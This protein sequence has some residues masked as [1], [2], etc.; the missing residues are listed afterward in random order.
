MVGSS[1]HC[2]REHFSLKLLGLLPMKINLILTSTKATRKALFLSLAICFWLL[3]PKSM[4]ASEVFIGVQVDGEKENVSIEVSQILDF[5]S[6]S[7]IS[8]TL[9]PSKP[10]QISCVFQQELPYRLYEVSHLNQ[11]LK[12][13]LEP[14][15]SI[16]IN[17]DASKIM[18]TAIFLGRG[19]LKARYMLER[20]NRFDK[21]IEFNLIPHKVKQYDEMEFKKLVETN[22]RQKELFLKEFSEI[23]FLPK[24]FRQLI[25]DEIMYTAAKELLQYPGLHIFFNKLD[26]IELATKYYRFLDKLDIEHSVLINISYNY[27]SFLKEYL[28]HLSLQK[29]WKTN[30][31]INYF[32]LYNYILDA[33]EDASVKSYSLAYCLLNANPE[34][35]PEGLFSYYLEYHGALQR[36]TPYHNLIEEYVNTFYALQDGKLAPP[37]V[38]ENLNG[39]SISLEDFRGKIVYLDFWASWCIPCLRQFAGADKL[40]ERYKEEHLV[41][42]YINL[43]VKKDLWKEALKSHPVKGYHLYGG[44]FEANVAKEYNIK[45]LPKY[46]LIDKRGHFI[47]VD[48]ARPLDPALKKQLDYLLSLR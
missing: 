18:E 27:T 11:T 35:A 23:Y 30:G 24:E 48:A 28:E 46:F 43:D 19:A 10:E 21:N 38:L 14:G 17:F 41:F 31:S 6:Y 25:E 45:T 15:D 7:R 26:S 36:E 42:L 9:I 4:D 44:G 33:F 22:R 3:P 47:S 5:I 1:T 32:T 16:W 12:L 29:G 40:H 34:N 13:Y 2:F 39:D 37:F 8:H 20:Q